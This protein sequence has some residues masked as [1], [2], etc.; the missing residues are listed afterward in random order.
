MK[1]KTDDSS[2]IDAL[3]GTGAVAAL[4]GLTAG[5]VSQ[6]RGKGIPRAWREFLRLARPWAFEAWERRQG[7]K[8]D[9]GRQEPA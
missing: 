2:L 9:A 5:A 6:W 1:A 8:G 7:T 3:G 4:C